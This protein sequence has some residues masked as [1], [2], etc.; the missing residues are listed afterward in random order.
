[1]ERKTL[2]PVL[3]SLVSSL[4]TREFRT[5]RDLVHRHTGIW[6]HDGK[7]VMLASRLSRRLRHH[8]LTN[9]ADYYAYIQA[10][11]DSSEEIRALINCVTTNKTSFFREMHHFDFLANTVVPQIQSAPRRD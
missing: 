6:L 8:G 7:Q 3:D 11:P 2:V 4:G 10:T 5:F 9:F 1:M